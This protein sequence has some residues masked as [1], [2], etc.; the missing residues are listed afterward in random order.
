MRMGFRKSLLLAAV[1]SLAPAAY[2]Q[3]LSPELKLKVE[4]RLK[5]LDSWTTDPAIVSAV[6]SF[7]AGPPA[8]AKEMT[9]EKWKSLTI[10]DPVV[11]SFS[12]NVLGQ[13]L[14]SKKDELFTE[15]FVSGANGGK[16]AFLSKPTNWSHHGKEKHSLPMSGRTYVGPVE[17]DDSTGLQQVQVGLPVLDGRRPIGSIVIGLS[18]R[19]L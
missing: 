2:S 12:G 13:Y 7:N 5:Q 3:Q 10:L 18:V 9:Q 19:K 6:K 4:Q 11:R 17:V 14:K 15:C 1:V 16:V 8:A